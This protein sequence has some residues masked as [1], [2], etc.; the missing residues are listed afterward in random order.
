MNEITGQKLPR[1]FY[2]KS[3][4][5]VAKELLRKTIVYNSSSGIIAGDIVETEAYV[6]RED[7]ACHAAVGKTDR[8]AVMFG[9]GGFSYV[10]FIYGMYNCFNIV[11]EQEGFPAAVLIRA[12]E[13]VAGIDIL[14]ANSPAKD[15]KF[16]NGPGK[17]C[18]AF[19]ITR[20]HNGLDLCNNTIYIIDQKVKAPEIGISPRI[21]IKKA[22]EKPW[23]FFD[24]DSC[25][26][27][28][29]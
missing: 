9:P 16:S 10:Y 22:K 26:I 23:R 12:V 1:E 4:V 7:P 8:N 5:T 17:F 21:G 2:L 11:T 27:S 29:K 24:C 18:R 25:Y 19:G 15:S 6:G 13:P 20:E 3:T 14:M 28:G